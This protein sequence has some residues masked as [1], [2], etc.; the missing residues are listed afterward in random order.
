LVKQGEKIDGA[1]FKAPLARN[2]DGRSGAKKINTP[3]IMALYY[4]R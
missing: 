2:L 4:P 3:L 1:A